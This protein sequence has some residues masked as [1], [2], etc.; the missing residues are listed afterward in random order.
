MLFGKQQYS[1]FFWD[2]YIKLVLETS[3]KG[4]YKNIFEILVLGKFLFFLG[5]IGNFVTNFCFDF[6]KYN[7]IFCGVS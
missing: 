4:K 2:K 5:D 7:L 1:K 6:V 3:L